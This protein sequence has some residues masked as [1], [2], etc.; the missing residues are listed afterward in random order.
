M[1]R[2]GN[3]LKI[4]TLSPPTF[5]SMAILKGGTDQLLLGPLNSPV[6]NA[7]NI[8]THPALFEFDEIYVL[9]IF[10]RVGANSAN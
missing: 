4:P 3:P 10:K 2:A 8:T 5:D 6:K 7:K 9:I 1:N